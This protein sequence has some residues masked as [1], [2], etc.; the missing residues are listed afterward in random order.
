VNRLTHNRIKS[1][2]AQVP[3]VRPAYKDFGAGNFITNP[4]SDCSCAVPVA[5]QVEGVG[6]ELRMAFSG[7]HIPVVEWYRIASDALGVT[8]GYLVGWVKGLEAHQDR[9]FG[10]PTGVD[11]YMGFEDATA[12][13]QWVDSLEGK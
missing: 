8:K 5:L 2:Y 13:C 10:P 1:Y 12:F 3:G 4:N 6:D 11:Q 9:E 7:A